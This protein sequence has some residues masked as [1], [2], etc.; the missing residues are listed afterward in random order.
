VSFLSPNP[1]RKQVRIEEEE[2]DYNPIPIRDL[3]P[4]SPGYSCGWE[5]VGVFMDRN[6]IN[7]QWTIQELLLGG[8][9]GHVA[10]VL[11]PSL[12]LIHLSA[13]R[14]YISQNADPIDRK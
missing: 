5:G 8:R 6:R 1:G 11:K 4:I 2:P 14:Y 7:E 12:L 13:T 9:Y 3:H 10:S